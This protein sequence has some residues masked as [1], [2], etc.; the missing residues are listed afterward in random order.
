MELMPYLPLRSS[1]TSK[2]QKLKRRATN[3]IKSKINKDTKGNFD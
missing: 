3:I 1:E 2:H